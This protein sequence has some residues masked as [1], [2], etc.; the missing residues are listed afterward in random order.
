MVFWSLG[1]EPDALILD[2][3][4]VDEGRPAHPLTGGAARGAAAPEQR[5][6]TMRRSCGVDH[7]PIVARAPPDSGDLTRSVAVR[8][9]DRILEGEGVPRTRRYGDPSLR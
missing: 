6:P 7:G 1:E 4:F 3:L 2:E 9:F 5:P 8:R